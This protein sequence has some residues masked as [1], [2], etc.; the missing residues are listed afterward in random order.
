MKPNKKTDARSAGLVKDVQSYSNPADR[1]P[2]PRSH[3]TEPLPE[4]YSSGEPEVAR[5]IGPDRLTPPEWFERW[6]EAPRRSTVNADEFPI[7]V[8][9]MQ[10][11]DVS[12]AEEQIST[13]GVEALAYYAPF[14][15]YS[16]N[17]WGIYIRDFGVAT[18]ASQFLGRNN[19]TAADNWVL[20]C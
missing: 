9:E 7:V 8:G 16:H 20:P 17:K 3:P 10:V 15:F 13:T 18:L 1:L 11:P 2:D 14:H 4:P 12:S 5:G 19:L 6:D